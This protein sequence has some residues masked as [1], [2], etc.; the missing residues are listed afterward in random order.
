MLAIAG[1][2]LPS[3]RPNEYPFHFLVWESYAGASVQPEA[4]GLYRKVTTSASNEGAWPSAATTE[5]A[6]P[7]QSTTL[8]SEQLANA[9]DLTWVIPHES[10]TDVMFEHPA[11]AFA[12]TEVTSDAVL[13]ESNRSK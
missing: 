4:S 11:K 3:A 1:S 6:F 5:K 13:T 7:R 9:P 10:V 8:R 12:P 2:S